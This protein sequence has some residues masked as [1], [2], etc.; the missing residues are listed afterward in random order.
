MHR[1]HFSLFSGGL[2]QSARFL[3][4]KMF[5]ITIKL[6]IVIWF[7]IALW[8]AIALWFTIVIKKYTTKSIPFYQ[9]FFI[10]QFFFPDLSVYSC[11]SAVFQLSFRRFH[12]SGVT[13]LPGGPGMP[14]PS[15]PDHAMLRS[16]VLQDPKL[17]F[18]KSMMNFNVIIIF[19]LFF[20]KI[21]PIRT[22]HL[23]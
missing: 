16:R 13:F 10:Y 2:N 22:N 1:H 5:T 18:R 8:S 11:F 23:V 9:I 17:L 20:Q 6:T 7:T 4:V 21:F 14:P 3:F 19:V 15:K 12:G